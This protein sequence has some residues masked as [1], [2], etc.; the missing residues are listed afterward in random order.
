MIASFISMLK[1]PLTGSDPGPIPVICTAAK[2]Q[3][4]KGGCY[5]PPL[6]SGGFWDSPPPPFRGDGKWQKARF[7]R[8]FKTGT[9][10]IAWAAGKDGKIKLTY[11]SWDD[12]KVVLQG[13]VMQTEWGP[14]GA[15]LRILRCS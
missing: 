14:Q 3:L 15:E 9:G 2:N 11:P 8:C 12:H 13:Q 1:C 5:L 6:F 4:L 10:A 7:H